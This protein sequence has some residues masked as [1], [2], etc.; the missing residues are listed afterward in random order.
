MTGVLEDNV[1][2]PKDD[3]EAI[4]KITREDVIAAAKKA[5]LAA[6]FFLKGGETE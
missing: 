5:K 2:T 4:E 6:V 1:I 3:K